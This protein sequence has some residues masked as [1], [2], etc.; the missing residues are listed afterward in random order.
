MPKL[1]VYYNSACP[2]CNAGIADQRRRMSGG[3][4]EVEWIDIDAD[5]NAVCEIGANREFVRKRLHVVDETGNILVG[6]Q[7]FAALWRHTQGQGMWARIIGLPLV[8]SASAL[9]YNVFA[10]GLYRW[11]RLHKRW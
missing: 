10:A 8:G 5:A 7:A 2:V 11:N 6:A 3:E 1:K 4:M 9:L